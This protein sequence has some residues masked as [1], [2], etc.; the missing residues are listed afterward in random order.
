MRPRNLF[1]YQILFGWFTLCF[2]LVMPSA[3]Q[4]TKTPPPP[5]KLIDVGGWRLH[6][7]CTGKSKGKAPT[8]VLEAGSGDFSVD[9][10]LVQ[11]EVARFARVCSYD[12]AGAGWSE[13]GPRPRTWRQIAYELHTALRKAGEKG[14]YVLVGQSLGGL[15]IRVHAS[16]Y[17][18]EVAGLVLVDSTHE[19]TVLMMN[20]KFQR[21]RELSRGRTIPPIRTT[22]S[23]AEKELSAEEKQ[24]TENFLK[25]IGA[26][27][28]GAPYNR[29]PAD[30]QAMRLWVLA[31]PR[32]YTADSY[33]YFEEE[34]AEVYAARQKQVYA[35]GDIPLAIL[36][37]KPGYGN[38]PPGIA[39]EEWKRINEEKRQQKVEF[40][41][42]SRNSKLM[43]AENSG[44]H[45][46][47]DE[48][49]VVTSAIQQVVGAVRRRTKLLP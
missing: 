27:K 7:N 2:F 20:G 24:R 26:P 38:P 29:L 15:L 34:F 16:Q 35:L 42:L 28:I 25:Q 9:W 48:P 40:T 37:T 44:H 17:A 4:E 46:H 33:T 23:A 6:L 31:Q 3:A 32:H 21:M 8:V 5:G 1:S 18:K 47:L 10:S 30:I 19:D 12:R 14:P 49:A 36:L 43:V 22:I 11:P 39:A 45:I 13:L 41:K